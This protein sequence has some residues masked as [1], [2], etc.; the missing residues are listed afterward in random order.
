MHVQVKTTLVL[1]AL[2]VMTCIVLVLQIFS[3]DKISK[4][5]AGC[6]SNGRIVTELISYMH[7]CAC[8]YYYILLACHIK[9]EIRLYILQYRFAVY[10][11]HLSN[12]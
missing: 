9:Q 12:F 7:A 8:T 10:C 5:A 2:I 11:H 6:H 3:S 1:S 4:A